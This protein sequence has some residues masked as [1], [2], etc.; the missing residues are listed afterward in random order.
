[1]QLTTDETQAI[2]N[3]QVVSVAI[4]KTECVILRKDLFERVKYLIYDDSE[5]SPDE[6]R[7][8]LARLGSEAGWDD[9]E[10]DIYD[11]YDEE[12]KKLWP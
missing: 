5:L 10:M 9:P 1:M 12:R 2:E 4:N 3:G 7:H 8:L 6:M 11:N